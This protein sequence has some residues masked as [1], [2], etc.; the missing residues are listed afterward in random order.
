MRGKRQVIQRATML[1]A[2]LLAA[3]APALAQV[4]P[5]LYAGL[6]WRN[7][8]PFHG[9][10]VAAV[11]GAIGQPG[12]FYAGLPQGGIWKT[13]SAG[14]TWK[15]IFD[16]VRQVDSIG[17]IA[18]APSNPEIIYVGTGDAVEHS[19]NVGEG[20]DGMYKSTD[21][22]KT[23]THIGL[24]GTYKI[25][26]ILVDPR[27]PNVVI[28]AALSG[29]N[30]SERGIFRTADGGKSWTNV[31]HP[32]A[33]TGARDLASPFD[34]PNVIF[35]TT[36]ADGAASPPGGRGGFGRGSAAGPSRT[37]LYKSLDEGK[38][39]TEVA[40][41]E[42]RLGI[43]RAPSRRSGQ[44]GR[45]AQM[46]RRRQSRDRQ[47]R[48]DPRQSIVPIT[49]G[50]T[51]VAVAMHTRGQRVFLIGS[52][53]LFRSDNQG[54]TW[55]RMAAGDPR[56][57]GNPYICGVWVD[58]QNPDVVYTMSTAA[59]RS[60]DGGKSFTAF[61]G[62]PGGED[63]HEV[64]IDP[65]NGRRMIYGNDQGAAV[66][67]DG[68]RAWSS[69]YALPSAQ[70][71]HLSTDN[72]YPYWVLASQQDTAA[73]MVRSRGDLG[74]VSEVDW[75]PLASSEFGTVTPDPIDPYI[76]Y[77]VGYGAA[78]GGSGLVKINTR[79]GQ[80]ET[81]A[82]NFGVD[83]SQYRASRDSW[84]RPDPFDPHTLYMDM[85]CLMVSHDQ[86]HSWR[87][88]SPDLTA[89]KGKTPVACGS[90]AD[91]VAP[92]RGFGPPPG[93]VLND[94]AVSTLKPG[95][96]W[97]VSSNGQIYNSFDA[98]AHWNNVSN[99]DAQG[100]TLRTIAAS[101]TNLETAYI[102]GRENHRQPGVDSNVPLIWRTRD[103]G[104][105]WVRIVN[106]L[107]RDQVSGSWVNIVR[108]DPKQ[109]GL[110]FCGTESTVFVSFD[111]GDHWQSLR[112]NLPT[113]SIRDMVFH[114]A[115]HMNDLVIAT[116]GRGLWVLD[117]MSPLREIAAK[118]NAIAAAP[119]YF[120][121]PGDAIR[122]RVSDNWDQPINPELP[123]AP[124]PPYG[125][126]FYYYLR[127]RPRAPITLRIY[128]SA[129]NLVRTLS[130]VP[131]KMPSRWPFPSYWV[132]TPADVALPVRAG[133]NRFN[134]NLRYDP[135]PTFRQDLEN[136]MN[137]E[138]GGFVTPGP[139]GPQV[140]PGVYTMKLTADGR[141]YTRTLTVNN[142]PRVG[143]GPTV[144]AALR[145]KLRLILLA[146]HA[147]QASYAG[148]RQIAAVRAQLAPLSQPRAGSP[149]AL[150]S[151][152]KSLR[153]SLAA[154]A[155]A[156]PRGRFGFGRR[157]APKPGAVV[158]F[159]ALNGEFNAIVSTQQVGLDEAPIQSMIDTWRADCRSYNATVA[160]WNAVRSGEL[161]AFNTAATQAGH[162][163]IHLS[164][165]RLE[166]PAC[167][168]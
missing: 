35:A 108:A 140:N 149:P 123:H 129:G 65:T 40:E 162:R 79:T 42:R 165:A 126:I 12:T 15:P 122:A 90:P 44:A 53:G 99:L 63:M 49:A 100:V 86:G 114:T 118:A 132:A 157:G 127:H 167:T 115:D 105:T 84:R 80:W 47:P 143:Q 158:P 87:P 70:L 151:R 17:A 13:T 66:T 71:Y 91:A 152:A 110:L 78:G 67:L 153:T 164:P 2:S 133:T 72:R 10:R 22:G 131:P 147:A 154:I 48:R 30:G 28:V 18:V 76:V 83:A 161:A 77:G 103:G 3:G 24:A 89:P 61:K 68:G 144:M 1:A 69:Y 98:G 135:P 113:T 96:F 111:D 62:A 38:T 145:A 4:N 168:F 120:F 9:G 34:M 46:S 52:G 137:V 139:H 128:D 136:E 155:G 95:V 74:D 51:A 146:Y 156:P 124:N 160:A 6:R 32:D 148:Y 54:A 112:Q 150:A 29:L 93:P 57:S 37:R 21:G 5:S 82:P 101:H 119:V 41:P 27:N 64:W 25:P 121:K 85:Q 45:A 125:A 16:Q 39:W 59:Y 141:T 20:G 36:I 94:F 134:W 73:I 23:W 166:Q 102:S 159:T 14:M 138:P 55:R 8:G 97:T 19:P 81:A 107:P 117:D 104:R 92:A 142:D 11:S 43:S 106:G 7:I 163:P 50:R 60:T 26:S 109:P 75:R 88:I 58:P 56:I 33:I 116:Y 130:S 31:L